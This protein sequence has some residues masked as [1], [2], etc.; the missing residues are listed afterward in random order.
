MFCILSHQ[1]VTDS[2]L[3]T[4]QRTTLAYSE[5]CSS[6]PSPLKCE[7]NWFTALCRI[8]C[9]SVQGVT[10]A[11]G[12][13]LQAKLFYDFASLLSHTKCPSSPLTPCSQCTCKEL[14][15]KVRKGQ[16]HQVSA[17]SQLLWQINNCIIFWCEL[18]CA[19]NH[20]CGKRRLWG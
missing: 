20:R 17:T 1:N 16:I 3:V 2:G 9:N 11:P 14:S 7:I 8:A 12:D 15:R 19:Q 4:F 6:H 5:F 18:H 13:L 10:N